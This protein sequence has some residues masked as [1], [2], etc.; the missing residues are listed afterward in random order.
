MTPKQL[1]LSWQREKESRGKERGRGFS[2]I[3]TDVINSDPDLRDFLLE[4][5]ALVKARKA[6][7]FL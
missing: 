6:M 1:E 7:D 4:A 3:D 2:A 5:R